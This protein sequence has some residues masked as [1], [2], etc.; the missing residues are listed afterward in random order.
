MLGYGSHRYGGEHNI[1]YNGESRPW[2]P[3]P[4]EARVDISIPVLGSCCNTLL[5]AEVRR[6]QT[7]PLGQPV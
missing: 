6:C 7:G 3:M 2:L 4:H 1:G 5:R